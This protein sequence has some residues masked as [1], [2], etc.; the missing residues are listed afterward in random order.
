LPGRTR[1]F[2]TG[3]IGGGD[4]FAVDKTTGFPDA[5]YTQSANSRKRTAT[6]V[7]TDVVGNRSGDNALSIEKTTF[8]KVPVL[9][10]EYV[11]SGG[12]RKRI[13]NNWVPTGI[14]VASMSHLAQTL[15]TISDSANAAASRSNPGRS[16]VSIPREV[17]E[18]KDIPHLLHS[19]SD[20]ARWLV[21]A[22]RSPSNLASAHGFA[23][24][25]GI[26]SEQYLGQQF[27]VKP[28]VD[29]V[30]KLLQATQQ[31][32]QRMADMKSLME[33]GQLRKQMPLLNSST[34]DSAV[35]T[36]ESLMGVL[37]DC[38]RSRYTYTRRWATV[39]RKASFSAFADP[40]YNVPS[41]ERDARARRLAFRAMYGLSDPTQDI[42][43]A[44]PWTWMTDW[45]ANMSNLLGWTSFTVPT[46]VSSICIMTERK[47]LYNWQPKPTQATAAWGFTEPAQGLYHTKERAVVTSPSLTLDMPRMDMW[48][49]SIVAALGIS[50]ARL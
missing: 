47:T 31:F 16:Y 26:A 12:A 5:N 33:T 14:S 11:T 38:V 49:A 46:T 15:P 37:V 50:R 28:L 25:L 24:S 42:Y 36:V 2:I 21:R 22:G 32:R 19:L 40:F 8:I 27:A 13:Y 29:D 45:F 17:Y 35:V 9:N 1:T 34:Q 41:A 6:W 20:T 23:H 44:M 18:L 30:V 7:C 39:K 43:K 3:F 48:R 4:G 10:G